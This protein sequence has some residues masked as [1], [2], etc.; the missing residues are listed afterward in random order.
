MQLSGVVRSI[1]AVSIVRCLVALAC[2]SGV[3]RAQI[4]VTLKPK[5]VAEFQAYA[6]KVE[7]QQLEPQWH[8]KHFLRLDG[9]PALRDRVLHGEIPIS[10][11]VED[12]PVEVS[13]GLVHDWVGDVFFPKASMRRVLDTLQDFDKHSSIYPEITRS[14]LLRRNGEA[15]TGYWRLEKKDQVIPVVLDVI[16]EAKY[17]EIAPGKWVSHAYA[18]DIV[19]VENAGKENEKKMPPGRGNGFLWRLYAYWSL[20][21]MDGGVMAECRTLSLS[22]GIPIGLGWAIKPIIKSFPRD[23][24][25]ATLRE[26]RTVLGN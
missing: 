21:A 18:N 25:T 2:W 8:S 14:H 1:C 9:D 23:S 24:L 7:T 15:V 19:E 16:D 4:P 3:A 11:G 17:Q 20:E 6:H 10:E 12:N 22:R 13:D 26:T 5:T